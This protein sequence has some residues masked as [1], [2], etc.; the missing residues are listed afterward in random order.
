MNLLERLEAIAADITLNMDCEVRVEEDAK[1]PFVQIKCWRKDVIT[2]EMGWGFG[3]KAY[4][5]EYASHS[6]LVQLIYGLY[7]GYWKHEAREGFQYKGVR[8]YGP[9]IDVEALLIAGRKIDV[10]SAQHVGDKA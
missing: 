2:G 6:E 7:E 4:P 9:H 8:V 1:G 10:R 5:S 3:G